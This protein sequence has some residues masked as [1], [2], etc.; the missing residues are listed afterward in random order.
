MVQH[1]KRR[2][3]Y[4]LKN[5]YELVVPLM[6][7]NE[8][9][10]SPNLNKTENHIKAV[11]K[12]INTILSNINIIKF[13]ELN[14]F[15]F[16]LNEIYSDIK[17]YDNLNFYFEE[18]RA[19]SNLD[20]NDLKGNYV[21]RFDISKL[22]NYINQTAINYKKIINLNLSSKVK[23]KKID[24][25][26]LTKS[27]ILKYA[28]DNLKFV[29]KSYPKI[30]ELSPINFELLI[31][32]FDSLLREVSKSGKKIENNDWVDVFLLTYVQENDLYWTNEK[33]KI[34]LI[35]DSKL[36]KYLYSRSIMD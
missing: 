2:Y 10:T 19:I 15:E 4:R 1:F 24:T 36:E 9:Y 33:S 20:Y 25:L 17:P 8:L 28:N 34:R 31:V 13:I 26:E 12:A 29:N 27:L 14:P 16:M 32:I 30:T 7:L 5:K 11:Q 22:T 23:F 3:I 6:I 18:F 21:R 35:K